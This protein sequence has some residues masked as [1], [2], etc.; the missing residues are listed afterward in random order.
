MP[1]TDLFYEITSLKTEQKNPRT[2][3]IDKSTTI[4]IL[5]LINDEDITVAHSVRKEL[6][7]IAEA[8]DRIVFSFKN[9]GRLIYVGAGTS[10]RLG[11]VDASECPPTDR[12]S[13]V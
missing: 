11:V 8:V 2:E 12:K 6:D 13:V 4:E 7:F 10:G 5:K 1:E 9:N 3:D